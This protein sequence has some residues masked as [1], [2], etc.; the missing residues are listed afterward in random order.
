MKI[1]RPES[2]QPIPESAKRVYKGQIFEVYEWPQKLFDGSVETFEKIK[3][4][5][6]VGVIPI[7]DEGKIL[8]AEQEQPGTVPFVG[9]ISGRM[10]EGEDPL[11]TIKR[12]FLEEAGYEAREYKLW[13]AEQLTNKIDWAA[14]IFIANGLKRVS[15]PNLDSGEKS[16]LLEVGFDEFI[17]LTAQ[18]NFRDFGMIRELYKIIN[19][20]SGL[21]SL[22][23]LFG[24]R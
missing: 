19:K 22:K 20:P 17:K 24:V 4:P 13:I 10:E 9:L 21:D 6:T 18:D 14:Y 12:E 23:K 11:T 1:I 3:R 15:E 8:L 2:N 7:T 16:K 5:D